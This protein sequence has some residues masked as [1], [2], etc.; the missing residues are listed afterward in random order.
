MSII[1]WDLWHKLQKSTKILTEFK[2]EKNSVVYNIKD[3]LPTKGVDIIGY[4][5]EGLSYFCFRCNCG[6]PDCLE[7]K[8]SITGHTLIVEIIYWRYE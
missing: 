7:W 8:C 5:S 1:N 2:F 4:D 3:K 6:N